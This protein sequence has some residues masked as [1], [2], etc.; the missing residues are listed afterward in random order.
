MSSDATYGIW[1][2]C[3]RVRQGSIKIIY[4]RQPPKIVVDSRRKLRTFLVV[5]LSYQIV[6]S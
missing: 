4:K 2:V 6:L 5:H 3:G 1:G